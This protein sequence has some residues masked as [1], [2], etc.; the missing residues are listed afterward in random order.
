MVW[1]IIEQQTDLCY[2]YH[3]LFHIDISKIWEKNFHIKKWQPLEA[4]LANFLA[5]NT[6]ETSKFT[7]YSDTE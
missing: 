2:I 4:F 3:R 6:F 7:L 5:I 1:H